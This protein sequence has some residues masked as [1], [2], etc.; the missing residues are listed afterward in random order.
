MP[1]LRQHWLASVF[2]LFAVACA[3]GLVLLAGGHWRVTSETLGLA[4]GAGLVVL[5][6]L[7]VATR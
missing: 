7:G 6:W 4:V 2:V 1:P 5:I 3:V